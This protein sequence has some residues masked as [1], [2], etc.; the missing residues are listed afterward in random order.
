MDRDSEA[1]FSP[2]P[3][4]RREL[5]RG[6][7]LLTF[8]AFAAAACAPAPVAPAAPA[9]TAP[10][11]VATPAAAKPVTAASSATRTAVFQGW[12]YFPDLVQENV[13]RFQ[14]QYPDIAVN[15]TPIAGAQYRDN[16]LTHPRA[17]T[18]LD[19]I[20]CRD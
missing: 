16:I 18:A 3:V 11:P 7:A 15:Y 12:D 10:A 6:G 17:N 19:V 20:Y 4:S 5:L 9:P 1:Q 8:G 13:S 2:R 14:T